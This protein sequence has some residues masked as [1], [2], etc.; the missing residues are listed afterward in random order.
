MRLSKSVLT[1]GAS[2]LLVGTA[3]A[4]T[5]G[6]ITLNSE[7]GDY[8]GMGEFHSYDDTTASL[9]TSS[10]GSLVTIN[11]YPTSG[12]WWTVNLAAPPG[13]PMAA[14]AYDNAVR[15]F[16]R[17]AG[18]PGIDVYGMGRGC[19]QTA[20]RFDVTE[21]TFGPNN[22]V[23][24]FSASFEQHCE[25]SGAPALR[26]EL[27]VQNPPPPP[28]LELSFSVTEALFNKVT[29]AALL[30]AAVS[31][32]RAVDPYVNL[33]AIQRISRTQTVSGGAYLQVHCTAPG[34][35]VEIPVNPP[36]GSS[37]AKGRPMEVSGNLNAYDPAYNTW[38]NKTATAVVKLK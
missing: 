3:G 36:S 28:A 14:G 5:T 25:W 11:V 8:I 29:G 18:T 24:S 1:L 6:T 9:S 23:T 26:G 17:P 4:Q 16:V 10:D 32:N 27:H 12:G 30:R 33:S 37:F 34:T 21:V 19:N 31:C 35:S 15:A 20:G 13:Q 22:Y 2:L 7:A 38:V